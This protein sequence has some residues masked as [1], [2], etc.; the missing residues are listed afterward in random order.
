MLLLFYGFLIWGGCIASILT[1]YLGKTA[2]LNI[3]NSKQNTRFSGEMY[4]NTNP[5]NQEF[6]P[7]DKPV[8]V[9]QYTTHSGETY[10]LTMTP[11]FDG[12]STDLQIQ[13]I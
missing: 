13:K 5:H 8:R 12:L 1:V 10:R 2:L 11:S 3:K 9:C 7:D 4:D 6:S